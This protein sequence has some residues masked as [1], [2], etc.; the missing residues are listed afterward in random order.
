MH[1]VLRQSSW[2]QAAM[3]IPLAVALAMAVLPMNITAAQAMKAGQMSDESIRLA[4]SKRFAASKISTNGFQV[5]VKNGIATL[6]GQT[7]VPQHKGV[8]TRLAKLAG[9]REVDN[10]I[11]ISEAGKQRMRETRQQKKPAGKPTQ[12]PT[13]SSSAKTTVGPGADQE[14]ELP[15]EAPLQSEDG[16]E[17]RASAGGKAPATLPRFTVTKPPAGRGETRSERR[18]Y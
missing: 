18:R 13:K 15:A 16:Q 4:I 5:D 3:T 6:R 1:Q 8:A 11:T 12:A 10:Q 2:R 17:V 7:S 9:A 14:K